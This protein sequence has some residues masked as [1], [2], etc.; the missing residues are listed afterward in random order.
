MSGRKK[1]LFIPFWSIVKLNGWFQRQCLAFIGTL[2]SLSLKNSDC[3][4][5]AAF[6]SPTRTHIERQFSVL[7]VFAVNITSPSN[8]SFVRHVHFLHP[9][10]TLSA[11]FHNNWALF[12]AEFHSSWLT[13]R[14]CSWP[15]NLPTGS[16]S[17]ASQGKKVHFSHNTVSIPLPFVQKL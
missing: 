15:A 2:T 14:E 17:L 11:V 4:Y 1:V 7:F 8:Q 9:F 3:R 12:Q 6:V 13:N 10:L 5:W 16:A